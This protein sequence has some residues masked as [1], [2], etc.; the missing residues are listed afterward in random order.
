MSM[1]AAETGDTKTRA[2]TKADAATGG[3]DRQGVARLAVS[4]VDSLHTHSRRNS[5][6]AEIAK[7]WVELSS[8]HEPLQRDYLTMVYGFW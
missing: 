2:S 6:S 3:G 1:S 5:S 7:T 4:L 8:R